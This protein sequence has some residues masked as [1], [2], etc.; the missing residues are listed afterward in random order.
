M[1]RSSTVVSLWDGC[2]RS[3]AAT[4]AGTCYYAH[5]TDVNGGGYGQNI[6]AGVQADNISAIITDLFYNGE[7]GWFNG[8]YGESQ[9]DMTNFEHWGHFSQIVWNETTHVGCYTQDCTSQGL[10]NV[11]RKVVRQSACQCA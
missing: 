2:S 1:R 4:I 9:P 6:A 7:V 8:L 5:S 10:G 11:P 3:T